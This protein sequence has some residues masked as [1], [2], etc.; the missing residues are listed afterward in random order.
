MTSMTT[1]HRPRG[2][3]TLSDAGSTAAA[4]KF[5]S[6]WSFTTADEAQEAAHSCSQIGRRGTLPR[7][8]A[9]IA[10]ETSTGSKSFRCDFS[11]RS[12]AGLN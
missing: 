9:H 5:V 3:S 12:V 7:Q 8:T 2:A 4:S 10:Q 1:H 6:E 11:Y